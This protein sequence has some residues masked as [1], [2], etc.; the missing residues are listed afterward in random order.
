MTISQPASSLEY[1]GSR[2]SKFVAGISPL[3]VPSREKSKQKGVFLFFGGGDQAGRWFGLV[4]FGK[5][6]MH[7]NFCVSVARCCNSKLVSLSI[8]FLCHSMYIACW[9]KREENVSICT[10]H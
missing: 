4:R 2:L 6:S 3:P 10:T 9:C 5:P 1:N 8:S 7:F